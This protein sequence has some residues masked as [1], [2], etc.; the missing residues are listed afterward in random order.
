MNTNPK[1]DC[2]MEVFGG[3]GNTKLAKKNKKERPN[4]STLGNI[5]F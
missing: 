3:I 4:T 5:I 2:Q 1:I